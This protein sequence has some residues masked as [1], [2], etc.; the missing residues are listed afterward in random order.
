MLMNRIDRYPPGSMTNNE[1]ERNRYIV[2]K[3]KEGLDYM[4]HNSQVGFQS[5]A[6]NQIVADGLNSNQQE[7]GMNRLLVGLYNIVII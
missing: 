6:N 5:Y 4:V 2:S 3:Y 1:E 7:Y